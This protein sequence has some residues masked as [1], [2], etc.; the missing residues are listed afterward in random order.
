MTSLMRPFFS[1]LDEDTP[2]YQ[3]ASIVLLPKASSK[4]LSRVEAFNS[5]KP[6]P[7]ALCRGHDKLHPYRQSQAE[8]ESDTARVCSPS[9]TPCG[10]SYRLNQGPSQL[11]RRWNGLRPSSVSNCT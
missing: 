4:R 7:H 10:A 5:H 6:L 1:C 9:S 8:I 11:Y 3:W 2:L